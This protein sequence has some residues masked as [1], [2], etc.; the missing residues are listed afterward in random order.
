MPK[1]ITKIFVFSETSIYI[2]KSTLSLLKL[3]IEI[4][5]GLSLIVAVI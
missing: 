1:I 4:P 3:I 2:V 5:K